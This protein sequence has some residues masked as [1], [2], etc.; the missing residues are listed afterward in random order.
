MRGDVRRCNGVCLRL[1]P[2]VPHDAVLRQ[3]QRS[4]HARSSRKGEL[5]PMAMSISVSYFSRMRKGKKSAGCSLA[6]SVAAGGERRADAGGHGVRRL[7]AAPGF[8]WPC[9]GIF[10]PYPG[11]G[12]PLPE[13]QKSYTDDST[14]S[15]CIS[16]KSKKSADFVRFFRFFLFTF[17]GGSAI[18]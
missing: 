3:G 12:F 9:I 13:N 14:I 2:F 7:F 17:R 16:K 1:F 5:A 15:L 11:A 18:L 4:R 10:V 8:H 6:A